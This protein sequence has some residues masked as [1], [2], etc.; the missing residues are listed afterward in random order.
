MRRNV[1][2]GKRREREYDR[3]EKRGRGKRGRSILGILLVFCV[4][5][6]GILTFTEREELLVMYAGRV[7]GKAGEALTK[8]AKGIG[9]WSAELRDSWEKLLGLLPTDH[10]AEGYKAEDKIFFRD[11]LEIMSGDVA[12]DLGEEI[13]GLEI[14]AGG[15]DLAWETSWDGGIHIRGENTDKMQIYIEEGSL[16]VKATKAAVLIEEVRK[17]RIILYI[18]E[19]CSFHHVTADIGVGRMKGGMLAAEGLDVKVGAG[20]VML[21]NVSCT[22]LTADA[23]AGRIEVS[24]RIEEGGVLSC[25][26]GSILLELT[27]AETDFNYALSNVAG[28]VVAGS[29]DISG[30]AKEE[31]VDNGAAGTLIID[32]SVGNIEVKFGRP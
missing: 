28:R 20:E 3:R 13:R 31:Q 25:A 32:C 18:P 17:G 2:Y 11:D 7:P 6:F 24:G 15:C 23:G 22:R 27:N 1:E 14:Y 12:Y 8:G 26:A 4:V 29:T 16:I 19:G 10:E 9:R 30:V 5:L 21:E